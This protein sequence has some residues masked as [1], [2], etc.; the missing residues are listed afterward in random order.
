MTDLVRIP[1]SSVTKLMAAGKETS[2]FLPA[3]FAR[4]IPVHMDALHVRAIGRFKSV[5]E[6]IGEYL[7]QNSS[8]SEFLSMYVKKKAGYRFTYFAK[9]L[10]R[11]IDVDCPEMIINDKFHILRLISFMYGS[12]AKSP[13]ELYRD[14]FTVRRLGYSKVASDL[15]ELCKSNN[16]ETECGLSS[17]RK[18]L[19]YHDRKDGCR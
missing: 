2:I 5:D 4:D 11:N 19:K 3:V 8:L 17:I 7:T 9:V 18:Q 15:N 12:K 16:I 13:E 6:L 14:I 1:A 10:A